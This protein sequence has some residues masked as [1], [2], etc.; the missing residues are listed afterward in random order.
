MSHS[1]CSKDGNI[2]FARWL[3]IR[4]ITEHHSKKRIYKAQL[5]PFLH[6][7]TIPK[8]GPVPVFLMNPMKDPRV[9]YANVF[10]Y[11]CSIANL[12]FLKEC[13][14]NNKTFN[15]KLLDVLPNKRKK[16]DVYVKVELYQH[17]HKKS[18]KNTLKT[19]SVHKT[20]SFKTGFCKTGSFNDLSDDEGQTSDDE[21]QTSDD[22]GQTSDDECHESPY[23]EAVLKPKPKPKAKPEKR[24]LMD[25]F[26][27]MKKLPQKRMNWGDSDSDSD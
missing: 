1:K 6:H 4:H 22:E 27:N 7:S 15:V 26:K 12:D 11:N 21:G 20:G 8:N 19:S 13:C 9:V 10:L 2:A 24:D 3:F 23:L 5:A 14:K 16:N 18:E 17:K 25:Q